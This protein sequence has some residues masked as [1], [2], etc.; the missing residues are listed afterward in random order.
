MNIP[1]TKSQNDAMFKLIKSYQIPMFAGFPMDFPWI[2]HG[3]PNGFPR[4]LRGH[5]A[6]GGHR[7][8][9]R[10]LAGETDDLGGF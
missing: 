5:A 1:Y 3:F 6:R 2:S 9:G 7:Q 8:S 10:I 4:S